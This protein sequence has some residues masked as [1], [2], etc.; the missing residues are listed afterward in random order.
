MRV[1]EMLA[2]CEASFAEW[3]RDGLLRHSQF[4]GLRGDMER[5]RLVHHDR[6][7]NAGDR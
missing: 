6:A 3:V 4:A 1:I 7:R 2:S 5:E